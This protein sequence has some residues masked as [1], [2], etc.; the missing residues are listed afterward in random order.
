MIDLNR[1]NSGKKLIGDL[2][3]N[4]DPA[5]PWSKENQRAKLNSLKNPHNNKSRKK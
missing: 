5:K 1:L 2:L 3:Q 4:N